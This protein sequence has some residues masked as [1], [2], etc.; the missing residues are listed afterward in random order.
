MS[1]LIRSRADVSP[2]ALRRVAWEGEGVELA[3]EALE[4]MDRCHAAFAALVEARLAEDPGALI[5]GTT[6]A[7]GDGAAVALTPEAEARRPT[8]LWTAHAFGEPLPERVVRAIVLARLSNF[9]DGHAAVRGSVA[10]A[11]AAMLDGPLPAV[12]AQGSGGS[13]E[14]VALGRLFYDLSA[15]LELTPK[16]RMAL[17]NGSPC[18]AALVADLALAGAGRLAL[19][20]AVFAL[21]A[22][23]IRAPLEAFSADL[24]ALWGDE[25][26]IAALRSLRELLDGGS[27]ERLAHQA[28]VSVRILPRV[29]GQSRR[30]Q[31]EAD[32]AA[33]V[34][35][36]SV[37]DNPVFLPPD[38]ARP[39]G[40]V[41]STGGYHN[42]RAA[43]A[44]DALGIAWAD[45]CQLGQRLTDKLL[46]HPV[47]APLLACDEWTMKPL[48]MVQTGWAEEARAHAGATLLSLGGFG[49]NDVPAMAFLAWRGADAA[50]RCLDAALAVLAALGAQVLHGARQTAPPALAALVE[51][52][53]ETFPP[54]EGVRPLG[55]DADALAA[56]FRRRVFGATQAAAGSAD[57]S[58][59]RSSSA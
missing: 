53:H 9:V 4:R 15:R 34:A 42:A 17:I 50:G 39:L 41:L 27:A 44:I 58:S 37:T 31:A 35:L 8:R 18:A 13:G 48:H 21:A 14:V 47:S 54:V 5:Y 51:Q 16:E 30:V 56:A 46:Q 3:P 22:E 38:G 36:R 23:A 49:Q 10:Q 29:L 57:G 11:V 20:E 6:T 32:A 52:V 43:A 24:E 12:P 2:A 40:A 45:L 28:P 26:E 19:A 25:H 7:P 33:G 59:G 55:P 1:V